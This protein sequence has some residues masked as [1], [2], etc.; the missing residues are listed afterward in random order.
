M[1][2]VHLCSSITGGEGGTWFGFQKGLDSGLRGGRR[3]G[4][5]TVGP[6]HCSRPIPPGADFLLGVDGELLVLAHPCL[7][8]VPEPA[9]RE[10]NEIN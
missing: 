4:S 6:Q 10:I 1:L 8:W 5:A 3:G 7:P 2:L 9:A